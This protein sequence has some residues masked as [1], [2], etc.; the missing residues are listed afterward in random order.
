M[1]DKCKACDENYS[2]CS[3][4]EF[5]FRN[6]ELY[7]EDEVIYCMDCLYNKHMYYDRKKRDQY[8]AEHPEAA[9]SLL[10]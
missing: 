9:R 2:E 6:N 4:C 7:K 3:Q 8:F 10:A 5:H 1:T